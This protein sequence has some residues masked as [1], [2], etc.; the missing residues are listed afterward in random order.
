[1][2]IN[3]TLY[4]LI[5]LVACG[6]HTARSTALSNNERS[7]LASGIFPATLISEISDMEEPANA[8]L[9]RRVRVAAEPW[10]KRKT[11]DGIRRKHFGQ[12]IDFTFFKN[13]IFVE[14][15]DVLSWFTWDDL[16]RC[17][18]HNSTFEFV[19]AAL[20][21]NYIEIK[22]I[23]GKQVQRKI[24][25]P[26]LHISAPF[27][28][29]FENYFSKLCKPFD[30]LVSKK[31]VIVL[32]DSYL[33]AVSINIPANWPPPNGEEKWMYLKEFLIEF[34]AEDVRDSLARPFTEYDLPQR[35][36]AP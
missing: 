7:S 18:Q 35:K 9:S 33:V 32:T 29:K 28:L 14:Y 5:L 1:M 22:T 34:V 25:T 2:N 30:C 16:I 4:A 20:M 26:P 17:Q 11:V 23:N 12:A 10:L 36:L 27:N 15:D 13:G 19:P 3:P 6:C 21:V 24:P 31:M 8:D